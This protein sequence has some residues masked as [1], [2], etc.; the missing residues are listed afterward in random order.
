LAAGTEIES[1]REIESLQLCL[2]G[3][4]LCKIV[5]MVQTSL[6]PLEISSL[7]C[8]LSDS[9]SCTTGGQVGVE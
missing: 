2:M 8:P 5:P 6:Q 3:L 9:R 7:R 1:R 4:R